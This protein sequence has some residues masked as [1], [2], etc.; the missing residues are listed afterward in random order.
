MRSL[1]ARMAPEGAWRGRWALTPEQAYI[2][3]G[4]DLHHHHALASNLTRD[5]GGWKDTAVS[6][7]CCRS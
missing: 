7:Y 2:R 5:S 4:P 1:C 6:R 3:G